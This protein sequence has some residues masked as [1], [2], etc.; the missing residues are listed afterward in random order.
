MTIV[1]VGATQKYSDGW[2]N[3][4]GKAPKKKTVIA[5]PTAKK[6]VASAKAKPK[7]KKKAGKKSK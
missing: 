3:C 6:P 5:Q 7:A 4:F 1:R 2:E